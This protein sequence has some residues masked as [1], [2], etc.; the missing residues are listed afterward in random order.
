MGVVGAGLGPPGPPQAGRL[1]GLLQARDPSELTGVLVAQVLRAQDD[2][3]ASFLL[4]LQ[5]AT[6]LHCSALRGRSGSRRPRT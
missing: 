4:E 3:E 2:P 6:E 5:P 1:P